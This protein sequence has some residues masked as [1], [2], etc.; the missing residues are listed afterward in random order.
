MIVAASCRKSTSL[1][2]FINVFLAV[3]NPFLTL[4]V[5]RL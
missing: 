1:L 5:S 4:N 2:N 3:F